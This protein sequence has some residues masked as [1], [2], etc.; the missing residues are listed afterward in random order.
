[1]SFHPAQGARTLLVSCALAAWL[2]APALGALEAYLRGLRAGD[3][4]LRLL[5]AFSTDD[6]L[7][8]EEGRER[9]RRRQHDD[10]GGAPA[11]PRESG[12]R[13]D[14]ARPRSA[15]AVPILLRDPLTGA[16]IVA[17]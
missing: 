6:H 15:P 2:G 12:P 17:G 14:R 11:A 16:T 3:W 5:P 1:M 8:T 9:S 7:D 13:L 4:E 10:R